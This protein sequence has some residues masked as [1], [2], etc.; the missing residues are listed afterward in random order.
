[1]NSKAG[2]RAHTQM[3]LDFP[4]VDSHV[5]LYPD[6]IA[7]K[8]TASLSARF[9]NAPAFDG[10][11]AGCA[12]KNRECGIAASLNLP[13]ATSARQTAHVNEWA[14]GVNR[15]AAAGAGAVMSLAALHPDAADVHAALAAIAADGFAGVKFHPEYQ[16]FRFN[17]A[18][19]D[20]C[21]EEMSG[22]GL[23][24][25]LHAGG[26]RV[27]DPPYHSTPAEIRRLHERFPRLRIVAA[28]LGGFNMW[29]VAEATLCG[30]GVYLDLSHTF[31]WMDDAQILRMIARHGAGRVLFGSDAPWQDQGRTLRA[32]L[33]LGLPGADLRRICHLN[34]EELFWPG[35]L[36]L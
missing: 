1:M 6:A 34:A 29:D 21:W 22:L 26:E 35:G 16:Q 8:V 3:Q 5:H 13:V 27:F 17:D 11:V 33:A 23:V 18:K 4:V 20:G 10:T 25:Y 31:G 14:A 2:Q 28:H 30:S 24:A 9:G 7:A 12:A 32:L 19:M 15:S 36:A